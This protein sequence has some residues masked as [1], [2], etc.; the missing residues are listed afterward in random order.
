MSGKDE[1]V[2]FYKLKGNL[3]YIFIQYKIK[4]LLKPGLILTCWFILVL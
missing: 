1:G 3:P 4:F 2:L